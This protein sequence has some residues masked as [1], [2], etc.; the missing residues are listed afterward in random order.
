MSV[1]AKENTKT[2]NAC[3]H[4]VHA[5]QSRY[6]VYFQPCNFPP[7]RKMNNRL[8]ALSKLLYKLS[9]NPQWGKN[10]LSSRRS[11]SRKYLPLRPLFRFN[12]SLR[13]SLYFTLLFIF[14][15]GDLLLRARLQH[16]VVHHKTVWNVGDC[17]QQQKTSSPC[18]C[19]RP[20]RLGGKR[21]R[22][23]QCACESYFGSLWRDL[24][25]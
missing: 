20:K 6:T 15:H 24:K 8:L 12:S 2:I 21:F 10:E 11:R 22:Q 7:P 14:S 17:S 5:K 23:S 18:R 13:L 3:T 1:G 19:G 9:L 25:G 4:H 16:N